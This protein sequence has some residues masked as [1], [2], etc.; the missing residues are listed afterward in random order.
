MAINSASTS[1]PTD[2]PELDEFFDA[3][4]DDLL[5]TGPPLISVG[6]ASAMATN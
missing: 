5:A 3:A 1:F 6:I 4:D 2:A